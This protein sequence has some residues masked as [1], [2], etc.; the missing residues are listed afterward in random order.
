[1]KNSLIIFAVL[2]ALLFCLRFGFAKEE[3]PEFDNLAADLFAQEE[4]R[5]GF[6]SSQSTSP[7]FVQAN[8]ASSLRQD[9]SLKSTISNPTTQN[10]ISLDIKGMDIVD[11]LKTLANRA[12]MN[13]VIGRN[14]TGRVTLFL[15]DVDVWDAFEILL[16]AND[17][18]YERKGDIIN[19]MT[20]RD[21]EMMYGERYKDKKIAKVVQLRY[22][23]SADL[24]RALNQIKTNNGKVVVDEGSNTVVLVD[25]PSKV[26]EMHD[27]I[28]KTDLP[29]KTEIFSLNYAQAEKVTPKIQELLTKG[30]G[31]IRLDERTNKIAVT[32]YPSKIEEVA[33]II[34]EF[35]EKTPQ[36]LIDAQ[37]VEV[38][39]KNEFSMGVNWDYWL[40][41]NFRITGF[42]PAL[43]TSS[44]D[45]IPAALYYG[46]SAA[47]STATPNAKYEQKTIIDALRLIG[48]TKILSSPRIMALNNQEAKILVGYKDAYITSTTSQSSAG[49]VVTASSV[50][51]VDV[52]IQL[53]VT[54]T[55]NKD[56]FITMKIKPVVSSSKIQTLTAEDKQTQV[57]IVTTSEA[58]TTIMLKDGSTVMIAGLKKDK[59][60]HEVRKVPLLG[61]I[62]ILGAAFRSAK[63]EN[64]KTELVI[65]IT[66]RIVSGEESVSYSSITKA[67]EIEYLNSLTPLQPPLLPDVSEPEPP[68]TQDYRWF[69]SE[70]IKRYCSSLRSI[71]GQ[72]GEI[73][74]SF[75]LDSSGALIGEPRILHSNN[76]NLNKKIK[77]SIIEASPFP[78]FPSS[79]DKKEEEFS[80]KLRF[81]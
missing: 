45:S 59:K 11:V 8:P 28:K 74:V 36:V 32:D 37:I 34:R 44:V 21:Y 58:E 12:N 70:K 55:I 68:N 14:V 23:K 22:A 15:K 57:P 60:D 71:S 77:E 7:V 40:S 38:Y 17:L 5:Q 48:E 65:F 25:I 64:T 52:G 2:A 53:Y 1:M 72:K 54:P 4:N 19:V 35:D 41:K 16:L 39:P 50:N 42:F 56:N 24:S 33:K 31:L 62:P 3:H 73:E 20:Q 75:K 80:I 43:S 61:D 26:K 51:F 49:T 76:V 63:K 6:D 27:F 66:P 46:V 79:L 29:L 30:V 9:S 69:I 78:P 10:K 81:E 18:A 13:L 47:S 67:K